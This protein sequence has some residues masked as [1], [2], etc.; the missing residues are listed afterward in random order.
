MAEPSSFWRDA[1]EVFAQHR[2][3][4]QIFRQAPLFAPRSLDVHDNPSRT[5]CAAIALSFAAFLV[6]LV[7]ILGA[8][9]RIAE[10]RAAAAQ[11]GAGCFTVEID[12]DVYR[13]CPM[14]KLAHA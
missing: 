7:L 1:D 12:G 13:V 4:R 5:A 14:G 11:G 9:Q 10:R 8:A 2:R 6:C 3:E